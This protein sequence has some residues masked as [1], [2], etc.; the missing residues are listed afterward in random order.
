[1]DKLLIIICFI[2]IISNIITLRNYIYYKHKLNMI[3]DIINNLTDFIVNH[4]RGK[5]EE[6]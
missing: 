5:D 6:K 2:L 1:M 4:I 3:E